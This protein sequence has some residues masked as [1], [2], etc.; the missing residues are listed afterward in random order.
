M[1]VPDPKRPP[2]APATER[3]ARG[4]DGSTRL[5]RW[6]AAASLIGALLIYQSVDASSQPSPGQASVSVQPSPERVTA[7]A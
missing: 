4:R 2:V 7:P 1:V 5:L 3:A 6:A